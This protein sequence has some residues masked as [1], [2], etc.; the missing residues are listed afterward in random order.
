M[1]ANEH[2]VVFTDTLWG[3]SALVEIRAIPT[4][5]LGSTGQ[6]WLTPETI[7][8]WIDLIKFC[9]SDPLHICAG[10]LPR[11]V[12]GRGGKD[13]VG[14]GQVVWADVDATL[15]DMVIEAFSSY[16]GPFAMPT[17]TLVI[18]SGTGTHLYWKM[19]EPMEPTSIVAVNRTVVWHLKSNL[20]LAGA[21][22]ASV[23]AARVM[24]V[25]GTINPK[26]GRMCHIHRFN[27]EA[28]TSPSWWH[29]W[30]EQLN[31]SSPEP[32]KAATIR[33]TATKSKRKGYRRSGGIMRALN[34]VGKID[35]KG[36][37]SRNNTA[38]R[39]AAFCVHEC[40]LN[41]EEVV[42]VLQSWDQRNTPPLTLSEGGIWILRQI[43]QNGKN[44]GGKR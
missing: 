24:R 16:R 39:I 27:A 10:V 36:E 26:Y 25:P 37:G 5:K 9:N 17:P 43:A 19:T 31:P 11:I 13:N 44:Y 28:I 18:G 42:L 3:K 30:K 1:L 4:N 15:P 20:G 23:D 2:V 35:G 8:N 34:Y 33:L 41:E 21:D 32:D 12:E 7:L 29:K 38:Y 14:P 6:W 40:G 22:S